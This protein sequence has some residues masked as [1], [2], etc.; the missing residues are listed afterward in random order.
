[1]LPQWNRNP[2]F[3]ITRASHVVLTSRDLAASRD[4]YTQVVGL[5]LTEETPDVLYLRGLE[6]AAHHSVLIQRI[7]AD[8]P[9]C[10]AVGF[11][12]GDEEDLEK[13]LRYFRS[14]NVTVQELSV[15]HQ[16]R[17]I[18]II[19]PV[20]SVVELCATMEIAPRF[21]QDFHLFR[22][23]SP[24]RLDHFQ[25][26]TYDVQSATDFYAELGFR[27]A[28]YTTGTDDQLWGSWLERKGNTHDLVFTN[29]HG[30]RLHHFAFTT[31][32]ANSLI[33]ACD[34]SS[35]LRAGD[36][37]DRGPGRHGI[38][39]ALFVYFRDPDGH[40]IELFTSHYQFIDIEAPPIRWDIS[41]PRRAQLWGFPASRRWFFEASAFENSP[42]KEPLLKA[43]VPTLEAYLAGT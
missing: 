16:G 37:I 14:R 5:V 32:D 36:I 43:D 34:V 35:S 12:V 10:R 24:Q 27:V 18:R 2:P 40:R 31:P 41:D 39:N 4:F 7:S 30:P 8:E 23:G 25:L 42:V 26:V 13:A 9:S 15:P 1:M 6:E 3:N 19:D 29:G 20:G 11:R 22:G 38:S 28:E 17:T 21:M 33:H